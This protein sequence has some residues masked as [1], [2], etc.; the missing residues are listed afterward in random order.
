MF[1][2]FEYDVNDVVTSPTQLSALNERKLV[3]SYTFKHE[4]YYL[5]PGA[6]YPILRLIF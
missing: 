6:M 4:I 5:R 2:L 1:H 3:T